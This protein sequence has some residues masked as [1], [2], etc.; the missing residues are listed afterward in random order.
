VAGAQVIGEDGQPVGRIESRDD[1]GAWSPGNARARLNL[2]AFYKDQRG[3]LIGYSLSGFETLAGGRGGPKS[4]T[5]KAAIP[6][7]PGD[8]RGRR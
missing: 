5:N 3:L 7:P 2:D 8:L 4:R 6:P 1:G